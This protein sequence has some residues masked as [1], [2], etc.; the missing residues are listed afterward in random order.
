MAEDDPI[1]AF[2]RG[3]ADIGPKTPEPT[4]AELTQRAMT[5]FSYLFEKIGELDNAAKERLGPKASVRATLG[6]PRVKERKVPGVLT[7]VKPDSLSFG[8]VFTIQGPAIWIASPA[9]DRYGRHGARF[10]TDEQ[11]ALVRGISEILLSFFQQQ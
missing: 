4:A 11:E 3:L 7:A 8:V 5:D 2:R 10:G 6:Q 9:F 1:E